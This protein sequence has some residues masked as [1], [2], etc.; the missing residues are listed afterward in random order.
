MSVRGLALPDTD[1]RSRHAHMRLAVAHA[2]IPPWRTAP[3]RRGRHLEAR[4]SSLK[5]H[6]H[7]RTT[8]TGE[9]CLVVPRPAIAGRG[10]S[11]PFVATPS[12]V[13]MDILGVAEHLVMR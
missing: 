5:R 4:H 12:V 6:C 2:T 13:N 11:H 7:R 8:S 3:T 9:R 1:L 10:F